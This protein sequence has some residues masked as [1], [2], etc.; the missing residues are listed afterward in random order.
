MLCVYKNKQAINGFFAELESGAKLTFSCKSLIKTPVKV[1][2]NGLQFTRSI[3]II[4]DIIYK[5][6][7]ANELCIEQ[8]VHSG[9]LKEVK[10][11]YP[12]SNL[13]RITVRFVMQTNVGH[14]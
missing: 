12:K 4:C 7:N 10:D 3:F 6:E 2:P 5:N 13:N 11:K 1:G 8:H 14:K 9:D